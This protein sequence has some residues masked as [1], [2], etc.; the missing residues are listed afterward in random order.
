MTNSIHS[1]TKQFAQALQG[2]VNPAMVVGEKGTPMYES[3]GQESM[4][5]HLSINQST[6]VED[7]VL[8]LEKVLITRDPRQ[9]SDLVI[10]IINK[11]HP[12]HGEGCKATGIESLLQLYEQGYKQLVIKILEFIP[13]FGCFKDY[14][15]LISLISKRQVDS[16]D[17]RFFN[18][19]HPLIESIIKYFWMYVDQDVSHYED[20]KVKYEGLGEEEQNEKM[21]ELRAK[22][23]NAGKWAPREKS[24]DATIPWYEAVYHKLSDP[25]DHEALIKLQTKSSLTEEEIKQ[26]E[27]LESKLTVKRFQKQGV[28]N[29][30]IRYKFHRNKKT[31]D[32]LPSIRPF[33]Q[34]QTRKTFSLLNRLCDVCE[35]KTCSGR[36]SELNPAT[37]PSVFTMKQRK[38]WLNEKPKANLEPYQKETGNRFP[39]DQDRIDARQILIEGLSKVKGGVLAPY[40]FV[41]KIMKGKFTDGD[42][43]LLVLE[44]QWKALVRETRVKIKEFIKELRLKKVIELEESGITE[45]EEHREA[46][47]LAEAEVQDSDLVNVLAMIDVSPSMDAAAAEGITCMMLSISLGIMASELN[48]GPFKHMALSFSSEPHLFHFVH[49][50]GREFTLLEKIRTIQGSMG[51]TTDLNKA[52][53]LVADTARKNGVPLGELPQLL[54]LSDEQFDTQVIGIRAYWGTPPVSGDESVGKWE[55]SFDNITQIF[56]SHGYT[57]PPQINYWNL[58]ARYND[59]KTHGY[60]AQADRKGVSMLQGWNNASFKMVMAGQEVVT[61]AAS[62]EHTAPGGAPAKKSAWDDFRAMIDQDCYVWVKELM[63]QSTEECLADYTFTLEPDDSREMKTLHLLRNGPDDMAS[64]FDVVEECEVTP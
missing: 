2:L 45:G 26:K 33:Y 10:A 6:P 63:S 60:Q 25:E 57:E 27:A 11:R 48:T 59:T 9:I 21:G 40:Q 34:K 53:K 16:V 19:Y 17:E 12:R 47:E 35:V 44:A 51:Y 13:E 55:T 14:W 30:L 56:L 3:T 39:E 38:A 58:N 52:M 37:A 46:V 28:R 41:E 43:E 31:F 32:V 62:K 61:V 18:F 5:W 36:W 49:S 42:A 50:S 54:I 8:Y 20:W 29:L 4:D 7:I 64:E 15:K 23:S 24:A 1:T 22:L